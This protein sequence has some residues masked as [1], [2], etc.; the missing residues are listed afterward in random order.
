MKEKEEKIE[1]CL[2]YFRMRPVYH[3]LF[4][5]LREKYASLG[6]MGGTV[7]LYGLTREEKSELGGFFRKDYTENKTVTIPVAFFE[8]RLNES[9]FSGISVKEVL[10]AYF[11]ENLTVK[12]EEKQK[13]KE[14]QK[15][16]FEEILLEYRE[17]P[18]AEWVDAVLENRS[19][20]YEVL[21]RQYKEDKDKLRETLKNLFE[22]ARRIQI[23][24]ERQMLPVFAASVSGNPHYFDY[25][26]PAEKLLMLF[27]KTIFDESNHVL[28]EAEEKSRLM[29]KTGILKD[30]LSNEV[31]I[32]GFRAWKQN[33]CIHEGIEGFFK[34]KEPLR[35]T[36]RILG[37]IST[38][39]AA[40]KNIYVVENPAVFSSIINKEVCC[41][42]VCTNGQPRLAALLF[43]D[44]LKDKYNF[45]YAGDFDPEGLLIAQRLKERYGSSLKFWQYEK[46]WYEQYI[47]DVVLSE[48]RLKKLDKIY[49]KELLEIRDCMRFNKKAAYQESMLE[50]YKIIDE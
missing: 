2:A 47:S 15:Q 10:E 21:I 28:S 4:I 43:L 18:A 13:S 42:A 38:V 12:K 25:G 20:G 29:Y 46:R 14:H 30:D 1:V 5:K 32:Y 23:Q 40:K 16:Y 39:E 33:Q 31:L 36:L 34:E 11:G 35:L 41:S 44:A 50:V 22:A 9:R 3:K 24:S 19:E 49:M 27:L 48:S 37:R 26:T 7:T 45:L 17:N 8:K 6:H